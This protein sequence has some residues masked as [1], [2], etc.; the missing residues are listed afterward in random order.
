MVGFINGGR[1]GSLPLTS[2]SSGTWI[3]FS[4][5]KDVSCI[6]LQGMDRRYL[7]ILELEDERSFASVN[8]LLDEL[9]GYPALCGIRLPGS[10]A[11]IVCRCH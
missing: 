8:G 9:G 1:A 6:L 3:V 5:K 7:S 4:Y 2:A 10:C 11:D